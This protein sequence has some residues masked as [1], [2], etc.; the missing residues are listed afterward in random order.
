MLQINPVRYKYNEKS[1]FSNL[2][3]KYIGVLA[4]DVLNVAPYMVKEE[5]FWQK[6]EEDENG[7]EK[8]IDEGEKFAKS[9][10]MLFIETSAKTGVNVEN[11]LFCWINIQY[12]RPIL[13]NFPV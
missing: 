10:D 6:V 13:F 5:N 12:G 9:N 2:N 11:V 1:G 7:V 3:Q 4:Q 8:I